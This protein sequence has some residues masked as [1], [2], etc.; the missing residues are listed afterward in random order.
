MLT[1][2][3]KVSPSAE[4]LKFRE[5]FCGRKLSDP[6]M[7]TTL[8]VGEAQVLLSSFFSFLGHKST[9]ALHFPAG[10]HAVFI[11]LDMIKNYKLCLMNSLDQ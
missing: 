7:Q 11:I 2:T 8:P 4:T 5:Q 6:F 3:Y 1:Y 10:L 9:I